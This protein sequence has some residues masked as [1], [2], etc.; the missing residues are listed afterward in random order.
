MTGPS[1]SNCQQAKAFFTSSG[2]FLQTAELRR[3]GKIS[4]GAACL[5]IVHI[6]LK[7]Y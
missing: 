1:G 2:A 5:L 4:S 7:S 3:R 6:F